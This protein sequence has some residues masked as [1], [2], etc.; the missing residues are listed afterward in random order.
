MTKPNRMGLGSPYTRATERELP[1]SENISLDEYARIVMRHI[2]NGGKITVPYVPTSDHFDVDKKFNGMGGRKADYAG[3][4]HLHSPLEV[5][6]DVLT[7]IIEHLHVL[8]HHVA[9]DIHEERPQ[10]GYW[11]IV[12]MSR[13]RMDAEKS[14][15]EVKI[16]QH[17]DRIKEVVRERL[18]AGLS[19][20]QCFAPSVPRAAAVQFVQLAATIKSVEDGIGAL[21]AVLQEVPFGRR[22]L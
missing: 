21:R 18:S 3:Q 6:Y 22:G 9:V 14:A 16:R 1:R 17:G 12:T 15:A 8:A 5:T 4:S 2:L 11:G 13:K 7:R 19:S 10:K 20:N